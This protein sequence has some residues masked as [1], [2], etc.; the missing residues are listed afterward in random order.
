MK[1]RVAY[2]EGRIKSDKKFEPICCVAFNPKDRDKTGFE[3]SLERKS[4][5]VTAYKK[6]E[7]YPTYQNTG[8]LVRADYQKINGSWPTFPKSNNFP[9]IDNWKDDHYRTVTDEW[10]KD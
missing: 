1:T 9:A 7:D 3:N 8:R 10:V 6:P 5:F 2:Q 4:I